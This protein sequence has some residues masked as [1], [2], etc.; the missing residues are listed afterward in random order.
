MDEFVADTHALIWYLTDSKNLG[1]NA[2]RVSAAST[3]GYRP[4]PSAMPFDVRKSSAFPSGKE[5]CHA[6]MPPL[7][8]VSDIQDN[9]G[10]T[11]NRIPILQTLTR[12]SR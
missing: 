6:A 12:Y 5:E 2:S 8:D 10:I 9:T 1:R 4:F 7:L 11:H 3:S